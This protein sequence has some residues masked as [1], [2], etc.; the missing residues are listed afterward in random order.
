MSLQ[1]YLTEFMLALEQE[2]GTA[3]SF[4]LSIHHPLQHPPRISSSFLPQPWT[5][6]VLDHLKIIQAWKK[7]DLLQACSFQQNLV[8]SFLALF[9]SQLSK[10]ALPILYTLLKDLRMLSIN[11]IYIHAL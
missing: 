9:S 7:Q 11:V 1:S 4:L 6:M 2:N 10:W 8:Q 5:D 3:L